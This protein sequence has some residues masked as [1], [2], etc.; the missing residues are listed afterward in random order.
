MATRMATKVGRGHVSGSA[1]AIKNSDR[2]GRR[3][4]GLLQ[5]VCLQHCEHRWIAV[6]M[7]SRSQKI[8]LK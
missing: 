5:Q 8:S 3:M 7:I 6:A 1:A 4:R 2:S